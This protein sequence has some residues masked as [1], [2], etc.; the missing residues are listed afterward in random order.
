[1]A[2]KD[3]DT[4]ATAA[5]A[6]SR[7]AARWESSTATDCN[8][9]AVKDGD[10]CFNAVEYC[11]E[12]AVKDGDRGCMSTVEDGN[13]MAIKAGASCLKCASNG[14]GAGETVSQKCDQR[15]AENVETNCSGTC[16]FIAELTELT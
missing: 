7:T 2:V 12:M 14:Q 1:M 15:T 16:R 8:Q 10:N 11:N 6:K 3:G 9:I 13:E 4:A 5:R